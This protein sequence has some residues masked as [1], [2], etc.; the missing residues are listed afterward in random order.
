MSA[1]ICIGVRREFGSTIALED[2][3]LDVDKHQIYGLLGPNGSGK[4]TLLNQIQGLDRPT[5]GTVEVLGLDPIANHAELV[6]RLCS[7]HQEST[8]LPRLTVRET[9]TLFASFYAAP[10]DPD[11]RQG[12]L[13][14][15]RPLRRRCWPSTTPWAA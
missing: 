15:G 9:I 2:V 6:H 7:Q 5:A 13:P 11:E 12:H 1:I 10:R 14:R 3:T 8:S 4:T